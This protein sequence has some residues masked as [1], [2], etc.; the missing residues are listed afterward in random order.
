MPGDW[1][2]SVMRE[3]EYAVSVSECRCTGRLEASEYGVSS[4]SVDAPEAMTKAFALT[5]R[6]RLKLRVLRLVC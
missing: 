5:G 6:L 3:V 1:M 4:M 2:S